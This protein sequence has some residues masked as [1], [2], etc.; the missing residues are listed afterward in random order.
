MSD[1]ESELVKAQLEAVADST[2]Q[3]NARVTKLA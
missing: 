2:S 3:A 1:A